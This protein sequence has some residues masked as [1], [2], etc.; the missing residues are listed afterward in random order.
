M[1]CLSCQRIDF[2]SRNADVIQNAHGDGMY[3]VVP[4]TLEKVKDVEAFRGVSVAQQFKR[5]LVEGK[6][7]FVLYVNSGHTR[8]C[9]HVW[10]WL[11]A[12]R[13]KLFGFL[14]IPDDEDFIFFC[15]V[16]Q[17]AAQPLDGAQSLLAT[18][19]DVIRAKRIGISVPRYDKFLRKAVLVAGFKYVKT[20]L[21]LTLFR[22]TI[23]VLWF[24]SHI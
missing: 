7:G 16:D 2:Y 18:C 23:T 9:G 3:C 13:R 8:M 15:H 1:R 14:P 10:V 12:P 17:H 6:R 24:P 20:L 19:V 22:F 21:R 4:F 11:T 5:Y